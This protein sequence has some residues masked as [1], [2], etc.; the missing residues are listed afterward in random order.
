MWK[1]TGIISVPISEQ[2]KN[3]SEQRY[4]FQTFTNLTLIKEEQNNKMYLNFICTNR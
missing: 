3:P 2:N 1:C 4:Y